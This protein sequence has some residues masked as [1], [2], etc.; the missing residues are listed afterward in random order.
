M[1]ER[2]PRP[3]KGVAVIVDDHFE[4]SDRL[5]GEL[6]TCGYHALSSVWGLVTGDVNSRRLSEWTED[7]PD[8]GRSIPYVRTNVPGRDDRPRDDPD[9]LARPRPP[10]LTGWSEKGF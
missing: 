6:E 1:E 5:A 2:R 7:L 10:V 3:R 8:I 9:S 4:R